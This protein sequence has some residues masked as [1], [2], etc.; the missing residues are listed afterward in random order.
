MQTTFEEASQCPKCKNPGMTT[1]ESKKRVIGRGTITFFQIMCQTQLCPWYETVWIVQVNED[2]S[3]PTAYAQ[4]LKKQYPRLSHEA[5][6]QIVDAVNNQRKAET[7]G[8]GE[9]RGR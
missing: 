6:Q 2:G 7:R 8:D 5:E 9:I 3:I 1:N 4:N